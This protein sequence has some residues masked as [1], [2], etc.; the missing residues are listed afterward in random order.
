MIEKSFTL[1]KQ[2]YIEDIASEVNLYTHKNTGMRIL[3]IKNED[4][5]KLFNISFN[6]IPKDS[7]GVFHI[8]E[9]S[10]LSGSRKYKTK[11]PFIDIYK[12]SLNT[13]MNAMTTLDL[14]MY[15]FSTRNEHDFF[16]LMDLYLDAVFFP[17]LHEKKEIF[18][19]E[20]WHYELNSMEEKIK[21][22]G[23][24]YNEMKGL[25]SNRLSHLSYCTYNTHYINHCYSFNSGGEPSQIPLL[26]Y[27]EFCNT[28][29]K[30]YHPSN[31]YIFFYGNVNIERAL[32]LLEKDY[33]ASFE[34]KYID[35]KKEL[36]VSNTRE[37]IKGSISKKISYSVSKDDNFSGAL[38]AIG[39]KISDEPSFMNSFILNLIADVLII[40]PSSPLRIK[41]LQEELAKEIYPSVVARH[42]CDFFIMFEDIKEGSEEKIKTIVEEVLND[43]AE[44]GVDR[45]LLEGAIEALKLEW[46][47]ANINNS[48]A[49]F[50][51]FKAIEQCNFDLD[52][53]EFLQINKITKELKQNAQ[54]N[55]FASFIKEKMLGGFKSFTLLIPKK[56]KSIEDEKR[57]NDSLF[58]YQ[59]SLQPKELDDII[60]LNDNLKSY[61]NKMDSED[62]KKS[63]PMLS[64]KD[65][66]K[67]IWNCYYNIEENEGV[68]LLHTNMASGDIVYF[69]FAFD[70]GGISHYELPIISFLTDLLTQIDTKKHEYQDLN[71]EFLLNT[72]G[73]SFFPEV[74]ENKKTGEIT[75]R[76][77]WNIKALLSKIEMMFSLMSEVAFDTIFEDDKRI[78]EILQST[79]LRMENQFLYRGSSVITSRISSYFLES[80]KLASFLGGL[81]YLQFL[82]DL[83]KN[84]IER[85]EELK[86]KL[87]ELYKSLFRKDN[88]VISVSTSKSHL[89]FI[90][91]KIRAFINSLPNVSIKIENKSLSLCNLR[92]GIIADTDV[93]YV[94]KGN[95]IERLG[96]KYSGE[97]LVLCNLLNSSYLYENIRAKGGAYG[98]SIKVYSNKALIASSYRD[99]NLQNTLDV[100]DNMHSF[101]SSLSMSDDDMTSCIVGSLKEFYTPLFPESE[102]IRSLRLYLSGRANEDIMKIIDEALCTSEKK[103]KNYSSLLEE[104][105]K[106]DY[107]CVLGNEKK[108]EDSKALFAKLIKLK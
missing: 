40:S 39:Y 93:V 13:F 81:D 37:S 72:G 95:N 3:H 38:F 105:F 66:K 33:L 22:N 57:V 65:I 91:D 106:S 32:S 85:K 68:T 51:L 23:V 59:Q 55:G 21:Y 79:I 54:M 31:A 75:I 26:T 12:S 6:T 15:P 27:E 60:N 80:S 10:V 52:P 48:H 98:A 44:K 103:L 78:E 42:R 84:F 97:L 9:H 46:Q 35:I 70:I 41:I 88:L 16:N 73:T 47:E 76:M 71:K 29:K 7:T 11:D 34:K 74:I 89:D 56:G 2:Q 36:Y 77:V 82:Q 63:L 92:E 20:G 61:I 8:I 107:I 43:I 69:D 17:I 19:R 62:E 67:D 4:D 87:K 96:Y 30:Y 94:G 86:L 28:H 24:V 101:L 100:F 5:N 49:L 99:P 53:F 50:Y 90:R 83:N 104:S 25:L 102:A 18:Y 58:L 1:E 64:L 108:I 14:T 45:K